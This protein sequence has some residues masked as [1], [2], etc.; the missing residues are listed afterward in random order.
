MNR[1]KIKIVKKYDFNLSGN[2]KDEIEDKI[3]TIMDNNM[4]KLQDIYNES[5]TMVSIK[6]IE[7]EKFTSE[8]NC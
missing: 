6:K 8:K 1:Y 2:S 5:K 4:L 3:K 7:K